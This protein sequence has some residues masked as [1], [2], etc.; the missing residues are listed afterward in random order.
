VSAL[1]ELVLDESILPVDEARKL[2]A[3]AALDAARRVYPHAGDEAIELM[4]Q[5]LCSRARDQIR[6]GEG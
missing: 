5:V 3:A 2:V 6:K 4:A 1:K